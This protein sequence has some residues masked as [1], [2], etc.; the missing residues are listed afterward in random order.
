MS[1]EDLKEF[2]EDNKAEIQA[3]VKARMIDQILANHSWQIT[4]EIRAVVQEFVSAEI[5]PEVKKHLQDQKGPI[6]QAALV[7]AS[8]IGESLSKSLVEAAAKNLA[9]DGYKFRAL[10]KA[11]FD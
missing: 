5:V 4:D 7:G 6:L 10:M 2:L 3:T 9:P 1:P 8:E 11:L